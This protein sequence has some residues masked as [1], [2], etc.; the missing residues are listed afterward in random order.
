MIEMIDIIKKYKY[1]DTDFYA[2]KGVT[3]SVKDGEFVAICGTSGSGKTT[4]LNIIGLIDDYSGGTYKLNNQEIKGLSDK[5]LSMIRNKSIGFVLQD[6]ALIENQTVLYNVMLPLLYSDTAFKSIKSTALDAINMVGLL[7]FQKKKAKQLSGGQ[8][9]RVAIAR[10]IVSSPSL[11]L[12]DEPTGQLDS[13][14]SRQIISLLKHINDSR[15]T[16]IIVTH[17]SEV[18]SMAQR[19]IRIEDGVLV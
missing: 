6:F 12:A 18:A 8:R 15:T 19:V 11:I 13:V 9:Q 2:L 10:A 4:L 5:K 1:G 17:D 7:D 14:S 16:V 3:L